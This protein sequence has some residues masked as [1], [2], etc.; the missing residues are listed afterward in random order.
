M[1]NKNI[2]V[3]L[4]SKQY[5]SKPSQVETGLISNRI[6]DGKQQ[7]T[8]EQLAEALGNGHSVLPG[9]MNG[10][11]SDNNFSSLQLLALDFD[12]TGEDKQPLPHDHE[13]FVSIEDIKEVFFVQNF[14]SF[15]YESF[16]STASNPRFRVVFKLD[17]PLT[18]TAEVNN[19]YSYLLKQF[20]QADR[21]AT[22]ATR[23]FYGGNKGYLE[24]NFNNEFNTSLL[25]E[26]K[27]KAPIKFMTNDTPLGESVKFIKANKGTNNIPTWKLIQMNTPESIEEAKLRLKP[28]STQLNTYMQSVEYLKQI[29]MG[30]ALGLPE[31]GN[32]LDIFHEETRPSASIKKFKDG[33]YFYKTF[34]NSHSFEGDI[35]RVVSELTGGTYNTNFL[36]DL[37]Q[38]EIV[39]SEYIKELRNSW[40]EIIGV[41]EKHDFKRNF[42]DVYK[43]IGNYGYRED[44]VKLLNIM[45][46][47]QYEVNGEVRSLTYMSERNLS[48]ELYG[49]TGKQKKINKMLKMMN[50]LGFINKLDLNDIPDNL[51]ERLEETRQQNLLKYNSNRVP[52][53]YELLQQ[54]KDDFFKLLEAQCKEWK[55]QGL[56]VKTLSIEGTFIL[57]GKEVKDTLFPQ[58]KFKGVSKRT[59]NFLELTSKLITKTVE[60]Q[61]YMYKNDLKYILVSD[62]GYSKTYVDSHLNEHRASILKAT[63]LTESKI[64]NEIKKRV[65]VEL[66]NP[67]S[68]P[69]IYF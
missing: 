33:V 43:V 25:P 12:N 17:K 66:T 3:H 68:R 31:K 34:S 36:R 18:T 62:Y 10:S 42:P 5:T 48:M 64:T 14:A 27:E 2:I 19:A 21:N 28:Y 30:E 13:L 11:R 61:G 54:G 53:V 20:P 57:W 45:V 55:S 59:L 65:S 15:I 67:Y 46:K 26:V 4:D 52:N 1:D 60:E 35:I 9:I 39:E 37:F 38:I 24:I 29:P 8:I 47:N 51:K 22:G 16:N 69:V 63:N 56:S 7:V 49:T 32:F 58:D 40:E 41:I 44:I 50:F 23:L 6:T